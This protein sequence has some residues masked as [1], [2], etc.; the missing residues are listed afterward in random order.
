MSLCWPGLNVDTVAM[1]CEYARV[2][3]FTAKHRRKIQKS[4][5]SGGL[6]FIQKNPHWKII[7]LSD[8]DKQLEDML[9]VKERG[10]TISL[11]KDPYYHN[12]HLIYLCS[13]LVSNLVF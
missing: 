7:Q 2:F 6:L 8:V 9:F 13:I 10:L 11:K 4:K 12:I 1:K 5:P 3:K